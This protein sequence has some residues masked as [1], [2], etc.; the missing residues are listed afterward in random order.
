MSELNL[1]HELKNVATL[2]VSSSKN[3]SYINIKKVKF[4]IRNLEKGNSG[5]PSVLS[6]L[7]GKNNLPQGRKFSR[8]PAQALYLF[9]FDWKPYFDTTPEERAGILYANLYSLP[10][11][12]SGALPERIK[13]WEEI[14]EFKGWYSVNEKEVSKNSVMQLK[15][16]VLEKQYRVTGDSYSQPETE[17]G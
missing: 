7:V 3:L 1:S 13:T 5:V 15:S 14:N 9:Y 2:M 8:F 10:K 4:F 6:T 16:T 17:P 12:F 11:E